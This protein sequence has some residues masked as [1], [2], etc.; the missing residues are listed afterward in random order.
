MNAENA[1]WPLAAVLVLLAATGALTVWFGRVGS[2]RPVLTAA[3]RA[4]VQLAAVSVLITAVLA[5]AWYTAGFVLLMYTVATVTAAGRIR[6]GRPSLRG[7]ARAAAA[8]AAGPGPVLALLLTTG[9]VPAK[10]V[11]IVPIAGILIGGAM[12]AT[13][14]AGRRARD[15]LLARRG[16]YEAALALGLMPRDAALLLLRPTAGEAL[17]PALDA[18]RT[19]GL[20]TLPGAFVGVLLGGGDPVDAGV[21]QLLVLVS[22]LTIEAVAVV[23]TVE[24]TADSA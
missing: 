15:E 14:L 21:V 7:T 8:I 17:V 19:V 4:A 1:G 18:T 24:L 2:W 5:S 20:V 13:S 3:A 16:E 22:L 23:V 9:A 11:T 12:R 6:H 10:P